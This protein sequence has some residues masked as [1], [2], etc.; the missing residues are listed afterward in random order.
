MS[1]IQSFA[2]P[3]DLNLESD[4]MK[5]RQKSYI[6][7]GEILRQ[8]ERYYETPR[9][10]ESFVVKSQEVQA[11]AMQIAIDAHIKSDGHCMGSLLWQLNDCYSGP[12][13]SVI[14]YYGNKKKAYYTVREAFK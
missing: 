8:I 5:Y 12:S 7:N 6:G 1:T 13:W 11:R 14:D 3:E 10:L 9:S 2:L 4:V